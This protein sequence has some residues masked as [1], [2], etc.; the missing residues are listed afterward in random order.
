VPEY[1]TP[2][3]YFEFRDAAPSVRGVRMDIAGFVG[4]ARRGPLDRPVRL[5]SWRQFQAEFGDF[6]RQGLLAFAVKGFFENGGRTCFVVRVA[7]AT[8]RKASRRLKN[9][10][11]DEVIEV[12]ALNE[13]TW[14]NRL[15]FLLRARPAAAEF[16]LVVAGDGPERESF[17]RLSVNPD[18]PRY[19]ARVVNEGDERVAPSR[20]ISVAAVEGLPGGA[21]LLP[22]VDESALQL[23]TGYLTGGVDGFASLTRE[24]FLGDADPLAVPAKGLNMLGRVEE[25]AVVCVPDIHVQP[26]PARPTSPPAEP[27]PADPCLPPK[28]CAQ[29]APQTPDAQDEQPPV[30]S[31]DDV[32]AV[33]RAMLEHCERHKDRVAIL[34]APVRAGGAPYTLAEIQGWRGELDSARGFGALY[35]PWVK[36][37][38]PFRP[39]AGLLRAVPPSGHVAGVYARG[40][41]AAGVHK[42][43]ANAELY[44]AEDVTVQ[45]NDEA[46]GVLNPAG[47]NCVRAFPGHGIRVYGARTVSD[48]ADWRYVNVRRLMLMVERAVEQATG[49]A[50]FEPNSFDLRRTLASLVST[51][52]EAVW[53]S[54]ALTGASA[55]EAFFVKCDETN[56][57]PE[58]VDEGRLVMDIGVAPA[59]PAEFII[60]RIGRTVAELE[61]VER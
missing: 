15:R 13:G 49:W 14:G 20:L 12:S 16:S 60:F 35:Y 29:P 30:F 58:V 31:P 54:G 34:D 32:L 48:D 61:A 7:G 2:G 41:F 53:Q 5:E 50:V 47:V 46:Q 33:Q 52:L 44:W 23:S 57:P 6:I 26:Q 11:G 36:V 24:D 1:L 8:A 9:K 43:P 27:P 40:D 25:V 45:V 38:D 51:F 18:D 39:G 37:V 55:K 10:A 22:D 21:D 19:F 3:V 17:Q 4:L 59:R 42:A 28:P 56:N